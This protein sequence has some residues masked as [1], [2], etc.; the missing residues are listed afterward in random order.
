MIERSGPLG[1]LRRL[2]HWLSELLT[3]TDTSLAEFYGSTVLFA[4]GVWLFLPPDTLEAIQTGN[5][6]LAVMSENAWG[7][8]ALSLAAFQSWANLSRG[9]SARRFAALAAAAF[10]GFIAIIGIILWSKSLVAPFAG[11]SSMIEGIVFL[12]LRRP[13]SIHAR[14]PGA[15]A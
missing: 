7:A 5:V 1:R 10:F 9:R 8:L 15:G 6:M 13:P 4:I 3:E 12:H 2:V 11:V 14:G